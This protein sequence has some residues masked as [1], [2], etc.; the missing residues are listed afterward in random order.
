[1]ESRGG[2]S[3]MVALPLGR[4]TLTNLY[5]LAMRVT[6]RHG[7]RKLGNLNTWLFPAGRLIQLND[8]SDFFLPPNSHFFGYLL[9]HEVHIT[10]LIASKVERG[11]ICLDIGS[12]IGYFAVQM[13]TACGVGGK[14]IAYEPEPENFHWLLKNSQIN[15]G[16]AGAIVPVQAAVSKRGGFV[17]LRKGSESTLHRVEHAPSSRNHSE[18]EIVSVAIDD[19]IRRLGIEKSIKLVKV[20]IEGS[21]PEALEGMLNSLMSGMIRYLVLEVSPGK[22]AASV[23][24]ILLSCGGAVATISSWRQNRWQDGPISELEYQTDVL[25]ELTRT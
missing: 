23:E 7:A 18:T 13:A 21:E 9:G 8:G 16:K 10:D 3:K 24:D 25:V 22:H 11:D 14:V 19:E 4:L 20:D 2:L 15:A 17:R 6:G 5:R 1:M 12:N